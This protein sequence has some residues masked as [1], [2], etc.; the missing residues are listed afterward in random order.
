[1]PVKIFTAFMVDIIC[2]ENILSY[3]VREWPIS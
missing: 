2:R 3:H 1:M